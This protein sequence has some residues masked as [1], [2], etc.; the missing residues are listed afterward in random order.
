[1]GARRA[2]RGR[3]RGRRD[4]EVRLEAGAGERSRFV[5]LGEGPPGTDLVTLGLRLPRALTA[6]LVGF[7]TGAA[8]TV[9]RSPVRDP[10]AGPDTIGFGGDASATTLR[11][12]HWP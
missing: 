9:L 2:Q 5:L 4:R 7:G 8:G 10:L 3:T 12:G 6:A 11:P 1:M